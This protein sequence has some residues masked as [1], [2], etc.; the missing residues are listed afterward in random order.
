MDETGVIRV[1]FEN[2][3]TLLIKKT[4]FTANQVLTAVSFGHGQSSEPQ[5]MPALSEMTDRVMNFS[6][7]GKL[8]E[9]ELSRASEDQD[10]AAPSS[11]VRV[12]VIHTQEEWAIAK[13]CMNVLQPVG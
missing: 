2:K 8:S 5:N 4:D 11:Q 3:V 13:A 1:R 6:G 12:L 7:L 10:I 9:D